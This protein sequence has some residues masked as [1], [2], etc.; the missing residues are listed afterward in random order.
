VIPFRGAAAHA[1][2][3]FNLLALIAVGVAASA[4]SPSSADS[5]RLTA[6][7]EEDCPL[8]IGQQV[9]AVKAFAEM[10]PVIRHPRCTN[11]HGG[12]NPFTDAHRG[13][14]MNPDSTIEQCQDCH[15]QLK[16]WDTPG[17][18]MFFVGRSNE[19]ICL[20]FK[21]FAGTADGFVEH[22]RNDHGGVQFIAAGFNGDRALDE[23][24]RRD[25]DVVIEKPPGTQAE[26]TEK[27][28]KW[29][30]AMGGEFPKSPA[31]GCLKPKVELKMASTWTAQDKQST[32]T[33]NV[34]ATV[35]LEP[36]TSGFVFSG[37]APLQHGHYSITTPPGCRSELKP[38]GG[39]LEVTEARFDVAEDQR[40]TVSLAVVPK[41][42]GGTMA[43]ICPKL[44]MALP[45]MPILPWA[46]EWQYLHQPDLLAG[47]YYFDD[48][49]SASGLSLGGGRKLVA[50]K[51]LRRSFSQK[52]VTA[53]ADK[54][55]FELWWVGFE[56]PAR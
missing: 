42:D 55:T 7:P 1:G 49:E 39:E 53:K 46:G 43:F 28:R 40:M 41:M 35:P 52:G 45:V 38:S 47:E 15:D 13:G 24:A 44:P 8:S 19:K 54:T 37:T 11:C 4:G 9:K 3:A 21:E 27:A 50:R 2:S 12:V 48:F 26:L 17:S 34:S 16:G 30:A 14:A 36:D 5:V 22:I 33:E 6:Q 10:M 18:P 31:C 20:Q 32:I 29:V 56:T 23:Q 25:F 51:E